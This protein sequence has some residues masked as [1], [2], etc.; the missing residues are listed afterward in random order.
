MSYTIMRAERGGY[1]V[2]LVLQ[3]GFEGR[4]N[5]PLFCDTL[6]HALDFIRGE[7]EKID[8]SPKP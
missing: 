4:Y 1:L 7:M 3:S 5:P 2:A 8:E 6:E